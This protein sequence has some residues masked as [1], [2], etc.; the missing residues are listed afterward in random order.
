M[1]VAQGPATYEIVINGQLAPHR[2]QQFEGL[3]TTHRPDGR[4]ILCGLFPDQAALLGLLNWLHD[5]GAVLI[6]VTRVQQA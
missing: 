5:L 1:T 2:L 3:A 6:S 4:T